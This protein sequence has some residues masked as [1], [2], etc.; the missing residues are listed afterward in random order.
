[1]NSSANIDGTIVVNTN[2]LINNEENPEAD[3][4][5]DED[6]PFSMAV[7]ELS[8]TNRIAEELARV[9]VK[10]IESNVNYSIFFDCIQQRAAQSQPVKLQT[11][12]NTPQ[13][14]IQRPIII[15]GLHPIVQPPQI[16]RLN[17]PIMTPTTLSNAPTIIRP[18]QTFTPA[19]VHQFIR[20]SRP[21]LLAP[22]PSLSSS[23]SSSSLRATVLNHSFLCLFSNI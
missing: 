11:V 14:T 1:M 18:P 17:R 22:P 16:I 2:E 19:L 9:S 23:P 4:D 7:K 8:E 15:H 5:D 20:S 13:I 3:D 6:D 12:P 10:I 21:P